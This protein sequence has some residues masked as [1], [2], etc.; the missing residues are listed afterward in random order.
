MGKEKREKKH[1]QQVTSINSA[2][3]IL[4]SDKGNALPFY[5]H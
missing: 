3:T 1:V 4:S 5:L 2:G